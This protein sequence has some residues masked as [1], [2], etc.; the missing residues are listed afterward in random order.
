[1]T[2][3]GQLYYVIFRCTQRTKAN[4]LLRQKAHCLKFQQAFQGSAQAALSGGQNLI[5]LNIFKA[6]WW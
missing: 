3:S 6:N 2:H 4:F 5:C 1:M